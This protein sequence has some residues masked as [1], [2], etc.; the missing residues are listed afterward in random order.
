MEKPFSIWAL[1]WGE[2][3]GTL[4]VALWLWCREW[5]GRAPYW[6]CSVRDDSGLNPHSG[7]GVWESGWMQEFFGR[8][9]QQDLVTVV[10]GGGG[11]GEREGGFW[12]TSSFLELAA[13][14]MVVHSLKQGMLRRSRTVGK[15]M[16]FPPRVWD[17]LAHAGVMRSSMGRMLQEMGGPR[18]SQG[19]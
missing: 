2:W 6:C 11:K 17:V 1:Y 8:W 18:L 15:M 7:S 12:V 4:E 5:T 10:W 13:S 14:W 19:L 9:A 3:E 16:I